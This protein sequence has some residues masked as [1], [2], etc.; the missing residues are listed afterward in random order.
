MGRTGVTPASTVLVGR[1]LH[2]LIFST[3]AQLCKIPCTRISRCLCETHFCLSIV[4]FKRS[5]SHEKGLGSTITSVG[6]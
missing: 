6:S 3:F 5:L 4:D 1:L 2:Q